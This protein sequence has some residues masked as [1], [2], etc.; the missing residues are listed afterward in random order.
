E[1][2]FWVAPSGDLAGGDLDDAHALEEPHDLEPA[3]PQ[4]LLHRRQT[5]LAI[6]RV[7]RLELITD[8]GDDD[9]ALGSAAHDK[10]RNRGVDERHVAG[11]REDG[12]AGRRL[13]PGE[14]T[15]KP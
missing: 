13:D 5:P 3:G 2:D 7:H 15:A 11:D 6:D 14:D 1:H 8:A 10:P 9:V 4:A 12:I